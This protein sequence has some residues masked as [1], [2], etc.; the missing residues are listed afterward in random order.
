MQ[1]RNIA[2][3]LTTTLITLTAAVDLLDQCPDGWT[4]STDNRTSAH[5]CYNCGLPSAPLLGCPPHQCAQQDCTTFAS[6]CGQFTGH[7]IMNAAG[8]C[9]GQAGDSAIFNS[10]THDSNYG[11]PRECHTGGDH[12]EMTMQAYM[13]GTDWLPGGWVSD[14]CGSLL[15]S[16]EG[17]LRDQAVIYMMNSGRAALIYDKST[18]TNLSD[19]DFSLYSYGAVKLTSLGKQCPALWR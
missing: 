19:N 9:K 4:A 12:A 16:C 10:S 8:P 7:L 17:G 6:L 3:I 15:N 18:G 11:N 2:L 1:N 14:A 13:P 5:Y